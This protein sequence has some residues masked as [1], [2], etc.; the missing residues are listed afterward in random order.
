MQPQPPR[1][2]TSCSARLVRSGSSSW[3]RTGSGQRAMV[4]S[5]AILKAELANLVV[6]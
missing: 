2:K 3:L 6:G 1:A 4:M 5:E